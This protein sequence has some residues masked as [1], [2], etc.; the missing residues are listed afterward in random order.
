VPFLL[1]LVALTVTLTPPALAAAPPLV[2]SDPQPASSTPPVPGAA[3]GARRLAREWEGRLYA[4]PG[5]RRPRSREPVHGLSL[6]GLARLP[7]HSGSWPVR[8]TPSPEG[9]VLGTLE[10]ESAAIGG[11]PRRVKGALTRSERSG[12]RLLIADRIP[13]WARVFRSEANPSDTGWIQSEGLLDFA[14]IENR[15]AMRKALDEAFA[16]LL[17]LSQAWKVE[18]VESRK[19]DDRLWYRIRPLPPGPTIADEGWIPAVSLEG[20]PNVL[21][22]EN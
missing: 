17:P 20:T 6:V 14:P 11:G 4:A 19:V 12:P 2:T 15:A 18:L 10:F 13:G 5:A 21:P 1:P 9:A 16:A 3:W 22:L 7:P 8:A